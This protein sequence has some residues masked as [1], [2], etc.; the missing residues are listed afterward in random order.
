MA[1]ALPEGRRDGRVIIPAV[2]GQNSFILDR[3]GARCLIA[4]SYCSRGE[5]NPHYGTSMPL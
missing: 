1:V 2:H 4:D 3:Y 5:E